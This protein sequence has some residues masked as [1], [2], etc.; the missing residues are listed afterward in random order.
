MGQPIFKL[1]LIDQLLRLQTTIKSSVVLIF[2]LK[3][4]ENY[5][6]IKRALD[7]NKYSLIHYVVT[8]DDH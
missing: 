7:H 1:E 6:L 5:R 4:T 8:I 2:I 3:K